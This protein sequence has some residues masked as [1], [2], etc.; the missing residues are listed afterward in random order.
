MLEDTFTVF[1]ARPSMH[2]WKTG[3]IIDYIYLI[4]KTMRFV[5]KTIHNH[6]IKWNRV[7]V[8]ITIWTESLKL[9]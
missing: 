8:S 5:L 4:H 6:I 9:Q 1:L 2:E 7:I 3:Y